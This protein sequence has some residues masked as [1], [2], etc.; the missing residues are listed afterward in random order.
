MKLRVGL[1]G[2]G[3]WGRGLARAI[4]E[5]PAFELILVCDSDAR[6]LEG[7]PAGVDTST[8]LGQLA[9]SRLDALF[10]AIDPRQQGQMAASLLSLGLPLFVEKPLA[11]SLAEAQQIVQTRRPGQVVF[12]DHLAQYMPVHRRAQALLR[13]MPETE[14]KAVFGLR[15]GARARPGVDALWTLGPHD[16]AL[17]HSFGRGQA[18]W[19]A[20]RDGDGRVVADSIE[21]SGG[22]NR[23]WLGAAGSSRRQTLYFVGNKVLW[24]DEAE[25]ALRLGPCSEQSVGALFLAKT[26]AELDAQL[27]ILYA[28][29]DRVPEIANP[30]EQIEACAE[31]SL[32]NALTEFASALQGDGNV[33][34]GAEE[35]CA[36]VA[37][38]AA[39]EHAL[40]A[41]ERR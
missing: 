1:I 7:A 29:T 18:Q 3:R 25:A 5:H 21:D 10:V 15:H 37:T 32:L 12:V 13:L 41:G 38:L 23:L 6:A 39:I 34:S 40:S 8:R 16:V 22:P 14:L 24:V 17:L 26:S 35:G 2:H 30:G 20:F 9:G 36:V 4:L 33:R 11:M 27:T 31:D 19:R 28:R